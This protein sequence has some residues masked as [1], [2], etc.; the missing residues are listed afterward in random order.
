MDSIFSD[1]ISSENFLMVAKYI[2]RKDPRKV[3]QEYKE[4]HSK[5]DFNMARG[6]DFQKTAAG[7]LRWKIECLIIPIDKVINF[8]LPSTPLGYTHRIG[9][10]ARGG[11]VGISISFVTP[12]DEQWPDIVQNEKRMDTASI[13]LIHFWHI[14]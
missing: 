7:M 5:E 6:I 3:L 4:S 2:N 13:I 8:D 10:T 14:L 11:N 1:D 12:D 9:R